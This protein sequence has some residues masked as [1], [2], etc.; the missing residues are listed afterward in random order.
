MA[1]K[2]MADLWFRRSCFAIPFLE[3]VADGAG[4][5]DGGKNA[6]SEWNFLE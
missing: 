5:N 4:T 1:T 6:Q 2:I 3:G